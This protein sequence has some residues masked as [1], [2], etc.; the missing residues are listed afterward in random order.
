[1]TTVNEWSS[2]YAVKKDLPSYE[3]SFGQKVKELVLDHLD[4]DVNLVDLGC[5]NLRDSKYFS[6]FVRRV[7]AVDQIAS[8]EN[9]EYFHSNFHFL[10]GDVAKN[11]FWPDLRRAL[12]DSTN[13]VFYARFFLHSLNYEEQNTLINFLIENTKQNDFVCFEYRNL[14]DR[15]LYKSNVKQNRWY[16]DHERVLDQFS[17]NGF[18][19][20]YDES[21]KGLSPHGNED[22]SISRFVAKKETHGI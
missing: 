6:Q 5:G 8:P 22:P 12:D 15:T 9:S 18:R 4:H 7:V 1:M 3:S 14:D 16:V 10:K 2:F 13:T 21:G 17:S 19:I 20:M 11:G